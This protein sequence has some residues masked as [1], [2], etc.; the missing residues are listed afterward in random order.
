ML[1]DK[2][3]SAT[4]EAL[5]PPASRLPPPVLFLRSA[6]EL[7][8]CDEKEFNFSND[9]GVIGERPVLVREDSSV[10][11]FLNLSNVKN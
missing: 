7:E 2:S 8:L 3:S 4:S 6:I 1:V 10:G 9:F 11:D 5:I